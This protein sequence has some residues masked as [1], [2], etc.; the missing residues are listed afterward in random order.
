MLA[1]LYEFPSSENID[2]DQMDLLE[3]THANLDNL[4]ASP[5]PPYKSSKGQ[6]AVDASNEKLCITDMRHVGDTLHIF[7]HIRKT[8]RIVSV[9]LQGGSSPPVFCNVSQHPSKR[10]KAQNQDA[11][12]IGAR[13]KWVPEDKVADAK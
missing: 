1:G 9:V 11:D 5:P 10:R 8:Y 13:M 2:E 12:D 7:S 6:P 3:H 4:L